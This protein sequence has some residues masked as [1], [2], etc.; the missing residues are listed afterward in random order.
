[1]DRD[2][3][4]IGWVL[5]NFQDYIILTIIIITNIIYV[6]VDDA[7]WCKWNLISILYVQSRCARVLDML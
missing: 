4:S 2:S 6:V 1:M 3:L 5:V 7:R